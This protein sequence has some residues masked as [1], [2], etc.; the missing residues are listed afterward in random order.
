MKEGESIS[1]FYTY[2]DF[3]EYVNKGKVTE[4][5]GLAIDTHKT[6]PL[7]RTALDAD[8]YDAGRNITIS[9][10]EQV[11][12]TEHGQRKSNETASNLKLASN[13]FQRLN[14]QRCTYSLGN[15]VTFQADGVRD[16]LGA[17]ADRQLY[18]A[19]YYGLINGVSYL[20]WAYDHIHV[21]RA[22]EFV[23]LVD[24]QTSDLR[25]GV[26]FWQLAPDRPLWATLYTEDGYLDFRSEDGNTGGL[27]PMS[28]DF[29]AYRMNLAQTPATTGD[30][31]TA[32]NY[33]S[34]PIVPLWGNRCHQSTIVGVREL[35]DAYDLIQSGFANDLQDCA[36]IYWIVNGAGG[37]NEKEL[38]RFR[39]RLMYS[40]FAS[41]NSDDVSIT[42]Y[43]Q[44]IPYNAREAALTR[45]RAQIY[46]NFGGLDVSNISS[47]A[48]TATEINAAY[49]PM[50]ENADDFEYQI[51]EAVRKLLA[52]QGVS[53]EDATPQFKRNRVSNVKEQVEILMLEAPYLDDETIL[54]KLPNVSEEE[55]D[56]IMKRKAEDDLD[57][58]SGG[59]HS[60]ND[61]EEEEE[62]EEVT[63]DG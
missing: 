4:F 32:H 33:S 35:I 52:L 53:A 20:Y 24:E 31:F 25:A 38:N 62:P 51:I 8:Q 60:G 63:A 14:T 5:V 19:G 12:F 39:E 10:V 2:Q 21:F 50:D 37:T 11:I 23:P 30:V 15:G 48:K 27:V 47:A 36:Q 26:R 18:T 9:Q 57:R 54:K 56:E 22:T 28:D 6:S 41:V 1:T 16:K 43:T 55:I 61:Q 44:E 46:D 17:E 3:E 34:L 40:H 13:F 29:Q 42:P 45:I 59:F 58:L 49:Q 7:C